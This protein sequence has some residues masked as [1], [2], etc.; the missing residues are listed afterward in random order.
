MW[1]KILKI[2]KTEDELVLVAEQWASRGVEA[3]PD[4]RAC[5]YIPLRGKKDFAVWLGEAFREL[6]WMNWWAQCH[7]SVVPHGRWGRWFREGD[8]IMEAEGG[9]TQARDHDPRNAGSLW[10]LQKAKN[11]SRLE[12]QF[13][14]HLGFRLLTYRAIR[15]EICTLLNQQAYGALI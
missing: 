5:R 14:G 8:V 13:W 9:V 15:S 11:G 6:R 7:H 12:P 4:P 2:Q 1:K 3:S 10:K